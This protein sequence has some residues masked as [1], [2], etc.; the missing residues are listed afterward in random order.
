MYQIAE[1]FHVTI[2][3]IRGLLVRR[4]VELR[5]VVHTLRHEAFDSLTTEA[6]YWLGFLFADGTVSF[7]FPL[8]PT[9]GVALAERWPVDRAATQT[10]ERLLDPT[11]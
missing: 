9:V 8:S 10:P 11:I 6:K 4:G 2:P 3:S 1:A 7:R 5:V